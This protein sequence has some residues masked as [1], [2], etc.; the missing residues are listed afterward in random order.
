MSMDLET[1]WCVGR[2]RHEDPGKMKKLI[3]MLVAC[4]SNS[5][6][7]R[8]TNSAESFLLVQRNGPKNFLDAENP[9]II[10]AHDAW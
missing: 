10:V 7:R 5:C 9:A 1:L 8:M 6:P 4:T 2:L 3:A